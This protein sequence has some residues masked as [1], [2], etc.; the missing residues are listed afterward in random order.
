ME[1]WTG[2]IARIYTMASC[3]AR[4]PPRR[5]AI[6]DPVSADPAAWASPVGR[7]GTISPLDNPHESLIVAQRRDAGCSVLRACQT[8]ERRGAPIS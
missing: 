5:L 2:G 6:V 1:E 4:A 3:A 8:N 7:R